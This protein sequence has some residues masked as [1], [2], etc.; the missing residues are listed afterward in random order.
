MTVNM[1]EYL[2]NLRLFVSQRVCITFHIDS[3]SNQL[4]VILELRYRTHKTL[5]EFHKYS[6]SISIVAT[7]TSIQ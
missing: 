7:A 6:I 4:I 3:F 2:R 5:D 1:E